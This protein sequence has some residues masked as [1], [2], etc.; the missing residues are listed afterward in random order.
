MGHKH[1]DC[2]VG[3]VNRSEAFMPPGTVDPRGDGRHYCKG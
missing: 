3:Y 2:V 1:S